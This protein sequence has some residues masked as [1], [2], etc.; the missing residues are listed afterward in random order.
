MLPNRRV[1]AIPMD[2]VNFVFETVIRVRSSEVGVGQHMTIEAL[3]ALLSETR[4]R[5]L[6]SKDIKEIAAD[7]TGLVI[8]D[9][10]AQFVSRVR[11]REELLFEVGVYGLH[12]SG[13]DFVFKVSRM[14]DGSAVAQAA[15]GFVAYDY[16]TQQPTKLSPELVEVLDVKPFV[17]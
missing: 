6:Y 5:F 7:Y 15:M 17:V 3:I 4:A 2:E 11:A 16:R 10:S 14:F 13:G 1:K 12:D 8:D 9:V